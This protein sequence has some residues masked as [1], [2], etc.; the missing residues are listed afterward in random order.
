MNPHDFNTFP[1]CALASPTLPTKAQGVTFWSARSA[2]NMSD[3]RKKYRKM[4]I[5]FDEAMRE[6]NSLFL[7]EQ[8]GNETVMRLMQENELVKFC[9][10]SWEL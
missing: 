5:K 9:V 1:T 6:S 7:E 4:R 3:N 8:V 2:A 10:Y